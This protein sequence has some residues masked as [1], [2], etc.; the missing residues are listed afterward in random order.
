MKVTNE[1]KYL[2]AVAS[3]GDIN[4]FKNGRELSAW[5]GLI[6]RQCS[7][8]GKPRLPGISRRGDVYLRQLIVHGATAV[9]QRINGK[10][11]EWS[12]WIRQVMQRRNK[13][14]ANDALAKKM[15][16]TA[17]VLL[18]HNTKYRKIEAS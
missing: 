15:A 7:T 16:R 18:K 5:L 13:N 17:Y 4:H 6:P 1:H 11:D 14:I 12:L 8:G 9:I 2:A 10:T 3:I